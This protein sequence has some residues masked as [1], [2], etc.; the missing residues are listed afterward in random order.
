[1]EKD[2]GW[3]HAGEG[4]RFEDSNSAIFSYEHVDPCV[5]PEVKGREGRSSG[6]SDLLQYILRNP[7]GCLIFALA[8][9]KLVLQGKNII[10]R[11]GFRGSQRQW[12]IILDDSAGYL[13]AVYELLDQRRVVPLE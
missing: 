8:I 2:G 12:L 13:D 7:G 4:I 5:S 10:R 3:R 11:N 9:E 6:A 1:M